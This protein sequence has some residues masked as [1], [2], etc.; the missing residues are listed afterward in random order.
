MKKL[1]VSL[2]IFVLSCD[3]ASVVT[4]TMS[5]VCRPP[6][7][8]TLWVNQAKNDGLCVSGDGSLKERAFCT[9]EE[10][11]DVINNSTCVDD[12]TPWQV[13]VNGKVN[14]PYD[15][16]QLN[17][18]VSV[19]Y[20]KTVVIS[21]W[22]RGQYILLTRSRNDSFGA[23]ID[24]GDGVKLVI[25]DM[26]ITDARGGITCYSY[27]E[28][29]SSLDLENVVIN[30]SSFSVMTVTNCDVTV[31][32]LYMDHNLNGGVSLYGNGSFDLK[33]LRFTNNASS[34]SL[35]TLDTTGVASVKGVFMKGNLSSQDSINCGQKGVTID[36]LNR[37]HHVPY[38]RLVNTCTYVNTV[39]DKILD[40]RNLTE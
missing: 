31:N 37:V 23:G 7:N 12:P 33:D 28:K 21:P 26:V 40:P 30:E 14:T 6:E 25:Q 10:A 27:G 9:I 20:A 8:H 38:K 1:P 35:L 34:Y 5:K 24:V 29:R 36:E 3:T 11:A 15:G 17:A 19:V 39:Q 16:I 2:I 18:R 4:S 22:L 13:K 32:G